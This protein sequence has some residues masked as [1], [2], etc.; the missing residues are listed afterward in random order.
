[1]RFGK[2]RFNNKFQPTISKKQEMIIFIG[3]HLIGH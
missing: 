3:L 2:P 1:M